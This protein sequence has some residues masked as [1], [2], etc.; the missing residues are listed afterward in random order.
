MV[1][2]NS[3]ASFPFQ[4]TPSA[5]RETYAPLLRCGESGISIH[6]LRMEGDLPHSS[7]KR[8]NSDFNPLPPHGGRLPVVCVVSLGTI[9]SIHSLRMEGDIRSHHF[10]IRQFHFNPLPPHGGR[11]RNGTAAHG[12]SL[13]FNPLPPHGG[14]RG[15]DAACVVGLNISI[16]SLRME[17]DLRILS[18]LSIS[19]H[20]NPL[21]PHGGR[22]LPPPTSPWTRQ[23]QSTPSAWRETTA[24]EW[25]R[26]WGDLFQSTPSAWRETIFG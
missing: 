20:F 13:H 22:Q 11:R 26:H 6:S 17:G 2:I 7:R 1:R 24:F 5:W 12:W 4:S 3:D 14:R 15:S 16:H 19:R 23:F 10:S 18:L 21:P 25:F 9:I 8:R